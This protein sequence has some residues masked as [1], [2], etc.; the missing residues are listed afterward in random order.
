MPLIFKCDLNQ[1]LWKYIKVVNDQ[2]DCFL[3]VF[4][5]LNV[6]LF[7]NIFCE[8]HKVERKFACYETSFQTFLLLSGRSIPNKNNDLLLLKIGISLF[9]IVQSVIAVWETKFLM[10]LCSTG[11]APLPN[12]TSRPL[13][14]QFLSPNF[15]LLIFAT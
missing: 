11:R 6:L 14:A 4:T 3:K 2:I 8:C 1:L 5:L 10:V 12:P 9:S 15:C 13:V 7:F